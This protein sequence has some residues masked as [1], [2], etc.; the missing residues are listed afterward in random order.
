MEE[1]LIKQMVSSAMMAETFTKEI[2]Q[3]KKKQMERMK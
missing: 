1:D 3:V 2:F